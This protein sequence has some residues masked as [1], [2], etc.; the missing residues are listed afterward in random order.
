M[1]Y[2]IAKGKTNG[3]TY[4]RVAGE[5]TFDELGLSTGVKT[6]FIEVQEDKADNLLAMFQNGELGAEFGVQSSLNGLYE[7]KPIKASVSTLEHA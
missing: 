6:G 1:N 2:S 3:K 4:I 7:I 5:S